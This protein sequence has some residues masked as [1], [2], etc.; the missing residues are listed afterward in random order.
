MITSLYLLWRWKRPFIVSF[1]LFSFFGQYKVARIWNKTLMQD[2]AWDMQVSFLQDQNRRNKSKKKT[3]GIPSNHICDDYCYIQ[4]CFPVSVCVW[5]GVDSESLSGVLSSA[6][7]L[8]GISEARALLARSI[9][10]RISQWIKLL[11]HKWTIN[12]VTT[13]SKLWRSHGSLYTSCCCN[14]QYVCLLS[15]NDCRPL[16]VYVHIKQ[17][18]RRTLAVWALFWWQLQFEKA[19]VNLCVKTFIYTHTP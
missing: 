3:S 1:L 17:Q 15:A 8:R 14:A 7:T 2:F 9:S 12:S 11:N 10:A 13:E 6:H 16:S 18:P 19:C 5:V 4:Y